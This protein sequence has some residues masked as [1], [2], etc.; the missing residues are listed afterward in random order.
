MRMDVGRM[1]LPISEIVE[2]KA[3]EADK[4]LKK[5]AQ[6]ARSGAAGKSDAAAGG[7]DAGKADFLD[8][9]RAENMDIALSRY[10][11]SLDALLM[12]TLRMDERVCHMTKWPCSLAAYAGGTRGLWQVQGQ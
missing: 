12:V 9:K 2:E 10:R 11:V 8:S 3:S 7:K 5:T 4:L 6:K 1:Q